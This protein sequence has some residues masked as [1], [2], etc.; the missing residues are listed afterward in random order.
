[1]DC[2]RPS[3]YLYYVALRERD[4]LHFQ[5]F[6]LNPAHLATVP[7]FLLGV[8]AF[9]VVLGANIASDP[10]A[11]FP[12]LLALLDSVNVFVSVLFPSR[13]FVFTSQHYTV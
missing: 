2:A 7:V 10:L 3:F 9:G 13:T 5:L 4:L 8:S 1:M 11:H 6:H 12:A